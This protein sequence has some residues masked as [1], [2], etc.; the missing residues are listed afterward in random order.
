M[1]DKATLR[2]AALEARAN[3]PLGAQEA[4]AGHLSQVLAGYRGVPTAGYMP[5][6]GEIDPLGPMAEASAYGPV[7][8]PVI[9]AKATP[10]TFH[11]WE[12]EA[13]MTAGTFGALIPE[14]GVPMIPQIVIVPLVAFDDTGA[15]L[16]YGGGFYD[17]TLEQLKTKGPVH[18]VGFAF[19]VQRMDNLPQEL[20]DIPLD[21]IV[22]DKGVRELD[23]HQAN[24]HTR[25]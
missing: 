18:A 22:T 20:T 14:E 25:Q 10:L 13:L 7:G 9:T 17:R 5:M 19:E 23:R 3:A 21:M 24:G 2:K 12:P 8:V 1:T 15:R 4:A 6:R 11:L 16:G